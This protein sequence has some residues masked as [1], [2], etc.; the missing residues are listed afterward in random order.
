MKT[1][2]IVCM[3]ILCVTMFACGNTEVEQA[4]PEEIEEI[5]SDV[6]NELPDVK[7]SDVDI[8]LTQMSS[9][10]VYSEVSN[11]MMDGS[12]YE[13][14]TIRMTGRFSLYTNSD[15]TKYYPVVLVEDAMACCQQGIEFLLE[16]KE[17]PEGYPEM[18]DSITIV[19]TFQTYEEDGMIYFHLIDSIME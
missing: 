11:M 19:G 5:I 4:Q 16:D 7:S 1:L 6:Q 18:D 12:L 10:M 8:D 14:K 9:T 13:G 3:S 2:K 15:R 17:Y